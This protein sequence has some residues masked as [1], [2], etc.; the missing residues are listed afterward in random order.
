MAFKIWKTGF[1]ILYE[2]YILKRKFHSG[3]PFGTDCDML[4]ITT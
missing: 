2:T 3:A 1:L 4:Y